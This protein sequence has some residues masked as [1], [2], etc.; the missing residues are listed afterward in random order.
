MNH[1][2][3]LLAMLLVLVMVLGVLPA[4][5]FAEEASFEGVREESDRNP[6]LAHLDTPEREDDGTVPVMPRS[7]MSPDEAVEALKAKMIART[8]EVVVQTYFPNYPDMTAEEFDQYLDDIWLAVLYAAMIHDGTPEGGDYLYGHYDGADGWISYDDSDPEV[9]YVELTYELYYITTFAQEQAVTAK[10]D[11]VLASI[12]TAGMT[13]YE[14]VE[15]IYNYI[16][17]CNTYD[18]AA[19]DDPSDLLAHSAYGALIEGTSVCDGYSVLFY[20]MCL[21]AGIDALMI[22]GVGDGNGDGSF[23][24]EYDGAHAWNVVCI[25]GYYYNVD[26][27]WDDTY[28]EAGLPY[29]YFLKCNKTFEVDHIRDEG[30]TGPSYNEELPMAPCNYREGGPKHS[31]HETTVTAP[32]CDKEGYTT[33]TCSEC[34]DSYADDYVDAEGHVY[35]GAVTDPTCDEDGYTVYTCTVCGDSFTDDVKE[36]LGHKN[37]AVVT[38]PTCTE[39]GYTTYTCTVCGASHTDDYVDVADHTY[40]AVVTAPTCTEDGYTTYTCSVCGDSYQADPVVTTGHDLTDWYTEDTLTLRKCQAEGCGYVEYESCAKNLTTGKMYGQLSAALNAAKSGDTVV[41]LTDMDATATPLLIYPGVTL[42]LGSY[43]LVADYLIGL[44]G[45]C[46]TGVAVDKNGEN[47]AKLVVPQDSIV[48]SA[49]AP[50]GAAAGYKVI[51]VW[52][53]DHYIFSQAVISRQGFTVDNGTSKVTFLPN[54]SSYIKNSLFKTDGCADNDVS[55]IISVSWMESGIRVTQEYF[56]T[57]SLIID[58]MNNRELY[59][60][61]TGCETKEDLVFQIAIVADSGV[62]VVSQNYVYDNY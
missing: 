8:A 62:Q 26:A 13:D 18:D 29:E 35:V 4:Q 53:G 32:T 42:D 16:I 28:A 7:F 17:G 25:D 12:I 20:R 56:Y 21:E 52:N 6:R 46:V 60:V 44:E 27:T 22:I 34:G 58:A 15:A 3:R 49:T 14:K 54:F 10:V 2:K 11:E 5:V 50:D 57:T 47:G 61:M 45:S 33:Y 31:Y 24:G 48:L 1:L 38:A 19:V 40:E 41:L 59:A 23:D 36:A 55:V 37:E 39:S 30:F 43:T 51:P 9:L